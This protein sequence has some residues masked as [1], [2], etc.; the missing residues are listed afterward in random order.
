MAKPAHRWLLIATF[1]PFCWLA[2][3]AVHE[4]G[5]VVAAWSSGGTVT[6][7]VLH[8]LAISR[9]DVEPNPHPLVVVWSGPLV[10]VAA[11]LVIWAAAAAARVRLAFMTRFFAGFCLIANGAYIGGGSFAGVGDAGVMGRY[12]TPIWALWLFGL[13]AVPLG[14]F[15]WHRLGP[16]FGFGES[17]GRVDR[18]AVYLSGGLLAFTLALELVFG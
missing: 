18:A 15:L 4:F 16:S 11:P 9:T 13:V 1:L 5:H 17:R 12:G 8:P 7:V 6:H 10:G 2:M 14:L 3:M